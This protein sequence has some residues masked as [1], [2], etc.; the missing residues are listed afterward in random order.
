M[1]GLRIKYPNA[2]QNHSLISCRVFN[3]PNPTG[4]MRAW[5]LVDAIHKG[6]TLGVWEKVENG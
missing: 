1:R 3:W 4:S 5:R 6:Q 2:P